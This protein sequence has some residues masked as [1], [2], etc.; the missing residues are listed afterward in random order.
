MFIG[1]CTGS[2]AGGLKIT[3]ILLLIRIIDREFKRI[4]HRHGVFAVRLHDVAIPE[5]AVQSVVSMVYLALT[6]NFMACLLVAST[7]VDVLTSITAVAT[8]MFNVGPGLGA[9]GPAEHFGHLPA[10]A[11]WVLSACMIAGRLEFYTA[12]V[13]FTPAF[14][15]R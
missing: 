2:T 8:C 13:L 3:R 6:L 7:G 4:V 14:W 5:T 9:V 1:G 15:R 12:F 10:F 11:K